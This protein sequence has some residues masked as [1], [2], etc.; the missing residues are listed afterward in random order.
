[1]KNK[2]LHIIIGLVL[3]ILLVSEVVYS[4]NNTEFTQRTS[5]ETIQIVHN[6]WDTEVASSTVLAIALEEVGYNV[7]MVSVD[8]AIMYESL[9]TG[10]SDAMTSAWLPVTHGTIY[11]SYENDV[12]NLGE[13]LTGARS[14][15]VVPTYMDVSSIDELDSQAEQTIMGVEPGAGIM[16]QTEEAM[17]HYPNL[18]DWELESPST[19]AMLASLDIAIQEQEEIVITGW[20][21]H[22]KFQEYDLK[23]LDDPDYV[24][25]EVEHIYTL[26][27]QGFEEDHPEAFQ[28]IDNFNWEVSDMESVTYEMQNGLDDRT[29][30]QNWIDDNREQVESWY[31]GVFD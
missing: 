13:N 16:M 31:E 7:T 19:G 25:G 6:P 12:V 18:A 9:A 10:E 30:A 26:V 24:Y 5:G 21:P 4:V 17:G 14:G 28:I 23:F 22:W 1:M 29:A 20:A 15:L 3:G 11:E 2:T 27:R 8:N